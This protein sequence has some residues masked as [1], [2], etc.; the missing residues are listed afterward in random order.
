MQERQIVS[1]FCIKWTCNIF[2]P[3]PT[4][5]RFELC[6]CHTDR[7][8]WN[9]YRRNTS[10]R[11]TISFCR[12]DPAT[13]GTTC[14]ST[15]FLVNW[16]SDCRLIATLSRG[17]SRRKMRKWMNKIE[18]LGVAAEGNLSL[19]GIKA[20]CESAFRSIPPNIKEMKT[21]L[22]SLSLSLSQGGIHAIATRE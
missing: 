11:S 18:S 10:A 1:N 13:Y 8:P 21:P 6:K 14:R 16:I 20:G 3:S 7:Y 19:T 17:E 15:Y 22:L 12:L 5:K 9:I 2:N 4:V